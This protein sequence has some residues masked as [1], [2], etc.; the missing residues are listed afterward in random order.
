MIRTLALAVLLSCS[1]AQAFEVPPLPDFSVDKG[2]WV[3]RGPARSW[4]AGL[5][6]APTVRDP[7]AQLTCEQPS[8][9]QDNSPYFSTCRESYDFGDQKWNEQ[10]TSFGIEKR[11]KTT[12]KIEDRAFAMAVKDSFG[13]RGFMAGIGR[14][15]EVAH[16]NGVRLGFGI[17]SGLWRRTISYGYKPAGPMMVCPDW[18]S[19]CYSSKTVTLNRQDLRR[20]TAFFVLP[21]MSV[22]YDSGEGAEL[23]IAPKMR[24]GN[25]VNI[26]ETTVMMQMTWNLT[27]LSRYFE[28]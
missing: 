9:P 12:D 17:S 13:D 20:K 4:H 1:A 26:P 2:E 24:I 16:V 11:I 28:R 21:F 6:H 7:S 18:R 19:D 3:I 10:N 25:L 14:D 22:N 27:R 8:G 5:S 15:W 23:A